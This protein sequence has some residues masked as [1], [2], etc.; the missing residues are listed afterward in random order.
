M[1]P[2][3]Q[4][5]GREDAQTDPVRDEPQ[6]L[7]NQLDQRLMGAWYVISGRHYS[8]QCYEDA[9]QDLVVQHSERVNRHEYLIANRSRYKILLIHVMPRHVRLNSNFK[10]PHS[11]TRLLTSSR[12]TAKVCHILRSSIWWSAGVVAK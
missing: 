4:A 8:Y 2:G 7:A 11:H 10:H 1:Q 12:S 9:Q 6:I 5:D 3:A